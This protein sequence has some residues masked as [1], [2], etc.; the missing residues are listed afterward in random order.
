MPATPSQRASR[1]ARHGRADAGEVGHRLEPVLLPDS[2]HD[3][4]RLLARR[5]AGAVGDGDEGGL[6]RAQVGSAASRLR[7]PA[8]VFGGK[9]SKEKTGSDEL[10]DLVD[11]H[12]EIVWDGACAQATGGRAPARRR[13]RAPGPAGEDGGG[14]ASRGRPT[15]AR[16]SRVRARRASSAR[17]RR[18]C[19]ARAR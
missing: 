9:N 14:R 18:R 15:R 2:L 4:D 3:L 10:E 13:R 16:F 12:P 7:S 11:S 19:A 6:Q 17:A 5:P 1:G 8:G